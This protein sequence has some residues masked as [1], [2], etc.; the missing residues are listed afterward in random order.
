MEHRNSIEHLRKIKY[1]ILS[2]HRSG[3]TYYSDKETFLDQYWTVSE[4]S[5]FA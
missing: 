1:D 2:P 4:I 5:A 3:Q